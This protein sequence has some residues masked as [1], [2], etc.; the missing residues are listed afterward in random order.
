IARTTGTM[1]LAG[2]ALA[3]GPTVGKG[4]WIQDIP[5]FL[6]TYQRLRIM[7]VHRYPLR[8]CFV[9]PSSPQYPT[10][11]HLLS[12]YA[13][14]GLAHS[15][16]PWVHVAHSQHRQLRLGELNWVACRG[17]QGVSATCASS[18]WVVDALFQLARLGVDGG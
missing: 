5:G 9:P 3:A 4:S 10:V 13:T 15:V 8:N 16:K 12:S 2:P 18:L 11:P 1:P 17:K 14:S 7:T 6:S